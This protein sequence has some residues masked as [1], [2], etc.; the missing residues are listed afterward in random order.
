MDH[1]MTLIG[2]H[3]NSDPEN[4]DL[5]PQTQ[6]TQTSRN[7]LKKDINLSQFLSPKMFYGHTMFIGNTHAYKEQDVYLLRFIAVTS[8]EQLKTNN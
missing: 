4:S 7:A 1:W 8:I 3:E 5:R 2:C 6:K